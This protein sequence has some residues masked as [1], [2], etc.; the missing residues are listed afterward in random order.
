MAKPGPKPKKP[1]PPTARGPWTGFQIPPDLSPEARAEVS[2]L[3]GRLR[4][5]RTFS[6]VDP[7]AV[8]SLARINALLA[9]AFAR[10]EADGI[11]VVAQNGVS[12]AHPLMKVVNS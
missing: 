7:Q 4:A 10:I 12:F 3:T 5:A 11:Q 8:L 6:R 2:R 9:Q 1:A